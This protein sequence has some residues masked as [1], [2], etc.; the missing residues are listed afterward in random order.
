MFSQLLKLTGCCFLFL[1]AGISAKADTLIVAV[2]HA[3]PYRIISG[4]TSK[5]AYSGI[6]IDIFREVAKRAKITI[7]YKE[8]PFKRA[9]SMMEAG[10]ADIMLGPNRTP[11]REAYMI[12]LDAELPRETKAFYLHPDAPDIKSYDG[13]SGFSVYVLRG[14]RYFDPFDQDQAMKKIAVNDYAVALR[15]LRRHK[16]RTSIIPEQQGDYLM[17]ELGFPLKK[18]SYHAPGKISYIAL[19]RQ[20][21]FLDEKV[22]FER[23]LT[24]MEKSGAIDQIVAQYR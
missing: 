17:R 3:P 11:E 14:A 12:Y 9:L 21:A 5:P 18:A 8:V 16:D 1:L 6:Y 22:R 20:S 19:S 13:L 24:E 10:T 7:T 23:L 2:N 4:Y 15:S